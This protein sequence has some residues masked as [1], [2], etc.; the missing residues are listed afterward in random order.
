MAAPELT[1]PT[2]DPSAAT[3]GPPE[4]PGWTGMAHLEKGRLRVRPGHGSERAV[5]EPRGGVRRGAGRE[6]H[7]EDEIPGQGATA[8]R[9]ARGRRGR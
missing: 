2:T 7:G 4:L 8:S 1:T 9:R 6:A 3:T 5:G